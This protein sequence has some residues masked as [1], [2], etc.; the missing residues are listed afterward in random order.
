MEAMRFFGSDLSAKF[1]EERPVVI[2]SRGHSGTRVLSWA[3]EALGLRLGA[4]PEI[5]S[6]DTQDRRFTRAIMR[7]VEKSLHLPIEHPPTRGEVRYFCRHLDQYLAWLGPHEAGWGWKF[8]ETYLIPNV[9]A[10][11]LPEARYLHMLRDGR[12]VAFKNHETDNPNRRLGKRLLKHLGAL[13]HPHHVQAA[14][15]WDFQVR[16]FERF[17]ATHDKAV[18]TLPFEALCTDPL[19][20]IAGVCRFLELPMTNECHGYLERHINR[21]KVAQYRETPRS[22]SPRP[23]P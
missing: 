19:G 17:L 2:M 5:P 7:L 14:M 6:G 12:D 21:A 11:A 23:R 22:R 16:R 8:P 15:S 18:H 9:V 4:R 10:A 3:L 13:G 20:T 1:L